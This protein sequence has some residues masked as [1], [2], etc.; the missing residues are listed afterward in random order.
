MCG[1]AYPGGPAPALCE[2]GANMTP[3]LRAHHETL[4][5]DRRTAEA[6]ILEV[7]R[8]AH[9]AHNRDAATPLASSTVRASQLL[10]WGTEAARAKTR[11]RDS[12]SMLT[13]MP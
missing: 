13:H 8:T 7:S 1:V 4:G 6:P 2:V 5:S 3:H 11:S 9:H 12:N 10:C